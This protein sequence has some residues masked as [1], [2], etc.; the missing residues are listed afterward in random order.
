MR[1]L[2]PLAL[3]C[4]LAG[5]SQARTLQQTTGTQFVQWG[6][7][8]AGRCSSFASDYNERLNEALRQDVDSPL[9]RQYGDN[10]EAVIPTYPNN[11]EAPDAPMPCVD[12]NSVGKQTLL[13]FTL[14][15]SSSNCAV[16]RCVLCFEL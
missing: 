10:C 11:A 14:H 15:S 3:I 6:L 8:L 12:Y 5:Q 4:L 9:K 16:S 2:V 1:L 7:A 13:H